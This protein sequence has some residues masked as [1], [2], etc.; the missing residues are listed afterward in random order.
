[1]SF[2]RR[3]AGAVGLALAL[4]VA[5]QLE[6]QAPAV[7]LAAPPKL[8]ALAPAVAL[9]APPKLGAKSHYLVDFTTGKVLS[10]SGADAE[11]PPA[12]L[13]KLMTA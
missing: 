10:A 12:S 4:L 13:T 3:F 1:M 9:P 8:D 11:L 2:L 6:A 7:A 5:A